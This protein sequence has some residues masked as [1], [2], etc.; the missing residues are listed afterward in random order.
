M[1]SYQKE[2]LLLKMVRIL[3]IW[4]SILT[5]LIPFI[6]VILSSFKSPSD[7]SDATNVF[8]TPILNNWTNVFNSGIPI[9]FINSF[10]V[11][12]ITILISLIV[13]LPAAY[14]ISK[15]KT[16]G[17]FTKLGILIAEVVPSATLVVPIFL[18]SYFLG[19]NGSILPVIFAHLTFILPIITWFLIGFFDA[20][21]NSLEE[22]ALIDGCTRFGAFIK[23][24]I[25]QVLP[26]VG[27]ASIFGFVLS[28]NDM[29]YALILGGKDTQTLPMAIAGYNT[30]RGVQLGEMSVAI[31]VSA[32]PTIILSFFIQK[33]LIKMMGGG[34][35]KE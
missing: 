6:W 20:V 13:G 10:I 5:V 31:L 29:F 25:P 3:L 30:F 22:Q 15:F 17:N 7:L 14:S 4:I 1:N 24:I 33:R 19:I 8:F 26:G 12:F 21:P 35:I 23:I 11:A 32:I 27:A 9:N 18:A 2:T 28:W 16:G 34:A